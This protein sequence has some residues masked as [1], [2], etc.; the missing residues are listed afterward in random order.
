VNTPEAKTTESHSFKALIGHETAIKTLQENLRGGTLPNAYLFTGP[1]GVGKRKAAMAMATAANCYGGENALPAQSDGGMFASVDPASTQPSTLPAETCGSCAA[2]QKISNG[3][4]P[5]VHIISKEIRAAAEGKRLRDLTIEQVRPILSE[6]A[7]RPYE[8]RRRVILIDNAHD[9]N[10]AAQNVL[11][12]SLEEPPPDTTFVLIT[13]QPRRL[14]PT[15]ISRCRSIRF[16]PIPADLADHF[17]ADQLGINPDA[18]QVMIRVAGGSLGKA[19]GAK[20]ELYGVQARRQAIEN[21]LRVI[22]SG[23]GDLLDLA[24]AWGKETDELPTRIVILATFF[25]DVRA[26]ADS[27]GTLPLTH[28]DLDDL[29]RSLAGTPTQKLDRCFGQIQTS[30]SALRFASQEPRFLIENLLFGLRKNLGGPSP[31]PSHG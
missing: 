26:L 27:G 12:K 10:A 30:L 31:I 25:R 11:L 13:D 28:P 4:H 20:R 23:G 18:A 17:V 7:F 21:V 19:L 9:L 24:E 14:L 3:N 6:L 5:D 16:G 2:C 22:R 29:A 1:E 15:V 8:G